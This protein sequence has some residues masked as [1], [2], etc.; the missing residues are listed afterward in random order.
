MIELKIGEIVMLNPDTCKNK[1]FAGCL[2]TITDLK[3]FGCMG[4]VQ[5]IGENGE[6]G[7]QAY[8]QAD[9]NEFEKTGGIA[10]WSVAEEKSEND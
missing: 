7:G 3:N 2:M 1:M 5:G 8:Y 9:W 6:M 10:P 4:F